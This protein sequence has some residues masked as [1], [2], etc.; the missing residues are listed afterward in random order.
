MTIFCL[1]TISALHRQTVEQKA[2]ILIIAPLGTIINHQITRA[3]IL[4]SSIKVWETQ[5]LLKANSRDLY[6]L[7]PWLLLKY[8]NLKKVFLKNPTN[9]KS[10]HTEL[11]SY[12]VLTEALA[13]Q[14]SKAIKLLRLKF[15]LKTVIV[16]C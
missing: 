8:L 1:K 15:I 6:R 12:Q 2:K 7:H 3:K 4:Y 5:E 9:N 11:I 14:D 16:E 10:Q 13:Y